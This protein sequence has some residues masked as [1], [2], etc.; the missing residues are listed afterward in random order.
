MSF[1][2]SEWEE[3]WRAAINNTNAGESPHARARKISEW[4]GTPALTVL[5]HK[6]DLVSSM[7]LDFRGA[8]MKNN[9]DA[10]DTISIA[11]HYRIS[12]MSLRELFCKG[13]RTLCFIA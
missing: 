1:M 7:A 4:T 8:I 10:L 3:S 12:S 6:G 9:Q 11:M 2:E 5:G 13:F